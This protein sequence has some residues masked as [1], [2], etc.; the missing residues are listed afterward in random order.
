[1]SCR[2]ADPENP[3]SSTNR[4]LGSSCLQHY[5]LAISLLTSKINCDGEAF[6][7]TRY[8]RNLSCSLSWAKV[9]MAKSGRLRH[10]SAAEKIMKQE[11]GIS[12]YEENL[13]CDGETRFGIQRER[14]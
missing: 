14:S 10:L 2:P 4:K 13:C 3:P 11:F 6:T 5:A 7:V 9:T 12:D 1:M 8:S